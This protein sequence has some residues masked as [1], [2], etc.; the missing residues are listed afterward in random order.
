[1]TPN[2]AINSVLPCI[3]SIAA[4]KFAT[5]TGRINF[6]SPFYFTRDQALGTAY[7]HADGG[8]YRS[9][10]PPKAMWAPPVEGY[11]ANTGV[12]LG[13]Y[14]GQKV[15]NGQ[16]VNYTLQ[17]TTAH[18]RRRAH[19]VYDNVA[20]LKDIFPKVITMNPVDAASRGISEGDYVY[21][22]NDWGCIKQNVMLSKRISQGI[23]HIGDGEWYRA[24]M[25]ETYQ[26]WFDMTGTGVPTM[27]TV[28]VD[29]GGAPNNLQHDRDVGVK[30]PVVTYDNC[31]HGTFLEV[32]LTHPDS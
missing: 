17:I 6:F 29:V 24:S 27:H 26:A 20:V 16:N 11:A 19:S 18:H 31:Y 30:E 15:K 9:L 25:S 14:Q 23:V 5:E 32:S 22:Y 7:Q 8:Y 28:P 4:G 1:M 10:Y 21:V 2:Q 13:Y 12:F 3:S